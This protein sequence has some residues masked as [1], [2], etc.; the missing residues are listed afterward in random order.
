MLYQL[1]TYF[2][3]MHNIKVPEMFKV[4]ES[5][6]FQQPDDY[7]VIVQNAGIIV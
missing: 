7:R 5:K 2:H 6:M 1:I 4:L 3:G